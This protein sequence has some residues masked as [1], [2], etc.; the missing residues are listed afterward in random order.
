MTE[1][2]RLDEPASRAPEVGARTRRL[3]HRHGLAEWA[4]MLPERAAE[5]VI[6]DAEPQD[7]LYRCQKVGCTEVVRLDGGNEE[8]QVGG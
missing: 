5:P 8:G 7:R 4:P 2:D 6:L 3:E 1:R